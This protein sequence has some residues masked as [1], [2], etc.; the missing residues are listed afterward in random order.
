MSS[1]S[2]QLVLG[3]GFKNLFNVHL[4]LGKIPILTLIFFKGVVQ[5][6]TRR[7]MM[8]FCFVPG[9]FLFPTMVNHNEKPPLGEYLFQ[10]VQ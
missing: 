2:T 5:P 10:P 7:Y 9:E 3:G 6:Q 8:I 1:P 4:Y